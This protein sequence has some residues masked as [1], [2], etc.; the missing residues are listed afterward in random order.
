[1]KRGRPLAGPLSLA[2][3]IVATLR[4]T[5]PASDALSVSA[6]KPLVGA[7]RWDGWYGGAKGVVGKVV[8][9]CLSPKRYQHRAPFFSRVVSDE[10]IEIGPYSQEI[11]D[12]ELAEAKRAGID[13]FAYVAY[14]LADPLA[15]AFRL[16]M[17]SRRKQ[18]VRFCMILE[19][20]RSG[21]AA[22]FAARTQRF[23]EH[24]KDEAYLRLANG[25]PLFYLGF[26]EE[27][28]IE[29]WG[30]K[31]NARKLWDGFRQRAQEAG[32]GNPFIAVMDFSPRRGK[33][34]AEMIG[35]DAISAYAIMGDG[36]NESPYSR[37]REVTRQF[38]N[39]ARDLGVSLI[40]T[41]MAGWDRRPRIERPHPWEPWQKAGEGMNRFYHPPTPA[42]LAEHVREAV[43]WLEA[44]PR[45]GTA[46][47][48]LIYAWNEH[49][50]GGWICPTLGEGSARVDALEKMWRS[51]A[52]PPL[53]P[54]TK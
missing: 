4:L 49:D 23:V 24:M 36:G 40:P 37:L 25:R 8:E 15:D 21:D 48:I 31:E 17:S 54:S 53:A 13:Y 14:D 7:I 50:E 9:E 19:A 32:A 34:L 39:E 46:G 2:V 27:R 29:A 1:M 11:V 52:S 12:R 43:E 30:G 38:W 6:S 28:Y 18:D 44:S 47:T 20:G 45:V 22:T 33:E 16:H 3:L 41:A 26:V 42:E 51:R 10:R 35:A 5:S